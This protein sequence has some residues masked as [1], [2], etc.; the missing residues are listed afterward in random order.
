MSD[1][2]ATTYRFGRFQREMLAEDSS[3]DG[4][5]TSGEPF[6][7][8]DLATVRGDRVTRDGLTAERPMLMVFSS[9]T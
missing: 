7:E 4:G 6:P 3:F 5:P 9:F 8:F 2:M 1:A